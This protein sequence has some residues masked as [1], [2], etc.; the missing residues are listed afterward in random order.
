MYIILLFDKVIAIISWPPVGER[1]EP[2]A[3]PCDSS[4]PG[5]DVPGLET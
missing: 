4:L 1:E 5:M 2:T 3:S